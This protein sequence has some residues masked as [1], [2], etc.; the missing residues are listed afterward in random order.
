MADWYHK[1]ETKEQRLLIF[2]AVVVLIYGFYLM[3]W[4]P[5]LESN[6][7]LQRKTAQNAIVLA[8]MQQAAAEI[9]ALRGSGPANQGSRLSLSQLSEQAAKSVGLRIGRFQPS[10]DDE[11]QVWLERVEY[12]K[13]VAWLDI[14]EQQYGAEL[15]AVAIN[16]ASDAGVVTARIRLKKDS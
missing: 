15:K 14:V 9:K 11:A 5:A 16:T 8:E 13:V 7:K 12:N 1:L 3:V 6:E 2:C 10:G 4:N